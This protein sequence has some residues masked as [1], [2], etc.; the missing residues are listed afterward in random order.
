MEVGLSKQDIRSCEDQSLLA[1]HE[2]SNCPCGHIDLL[3][4]L[5]EGKNEKT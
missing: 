4:S 5:G 2:S 1:F 3:I